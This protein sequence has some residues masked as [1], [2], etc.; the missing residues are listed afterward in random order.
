MAGGVAARAGA[1]QDHLLG[2]DFFDDGPD[3]PVEDLVG[4]LDHCSTSPRS[5]SSLSA[6]SRSIAGTSRISSAGSSFGI[7]SAIRGS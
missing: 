1:E 6:I 7:A 4:H 2:V 5:F 3:H